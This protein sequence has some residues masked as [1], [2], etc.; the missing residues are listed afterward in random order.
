MWFF[1]GQPKNSLNFFIV[2]V[3]ASGIDKTAHLW[4]EVCW[5][6]G[7]L[8]FLHQD[9]AG[10]LFGYRVAAA[11]RNTKTDA[12]G[13]ICL[14]VTEPFCLVFLMSSMVHVPVADHVAILSGDLE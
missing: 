7:R 8:H 1:P 4:G 2:G 12:H 11:A 13:L 14:C 3:A 10:E 9:D 6:W 5:S